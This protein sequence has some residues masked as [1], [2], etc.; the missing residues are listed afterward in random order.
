MPMAEPIPDWY[1]LLPD[2][3]NAK[4]LWRWQMGI[5]KKKLKPIY[6]IAK[7]QNLKD[8]NKF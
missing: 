5:N 3:N 7:K 8:Y 6:S 1:L 4:L 2:R